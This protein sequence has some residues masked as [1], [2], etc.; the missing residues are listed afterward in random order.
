MVFPWFRG[1]VPCF[2]SRFD[3]AAL[4][5]APVFAA[6]AFRRGGQPDC[7]CGWRGGRQG[8]GLE[9][10]QGEGKALVSGGER[11]PERLGAPDSGLAPPPKAQ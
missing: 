11:V 10:G 3:A 4:R 5:E 8:Q 2:S 1:D 6:P 9:E 7:L